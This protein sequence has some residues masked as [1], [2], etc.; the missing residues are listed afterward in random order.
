MQTE[1]LVDWLKL[2][3]DWTRYCKLVDAIGNELNERKLRFDKSD[4][5]ERSLEVF[6][7]GAM[8]YVNREGVDHEITNGPTVEMKFTDG[9][10]FTQKGKLKKH[11]ADLQLM[12]SRGSSAG[13]ELPENYADFLL[14]CDSRSAAVVDK[15]TLKQYVV[16]AGDGLKTSKMPPNAVQFVFTPADVQFD[17]LNEIYSYRQAK[18]QM[19]LDYLSKF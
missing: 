15:Q 1:Q 14:I 17:K 10:L 7:N 12:N 13:R 4:L 3:V 8:R 6:S 11:I 19:Q 16:D 2:N 9:A 18:E 5:F